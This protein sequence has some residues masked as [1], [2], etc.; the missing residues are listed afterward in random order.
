MYHYYKNVLNCI[1]FLVS[2]R[3]EVQF[4][5]EYSEI[6]FGERKRAKWN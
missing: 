5:S 2:V 3:A 4:D 6:T 1:L